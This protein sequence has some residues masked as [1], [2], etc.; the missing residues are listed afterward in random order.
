MAE[1]VVAVW[2]VAGSDVVVVVCCFGVT[3]KLN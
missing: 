3:A 1:W 2:A